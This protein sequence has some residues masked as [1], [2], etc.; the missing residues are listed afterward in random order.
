MFKIIFLNFFL[1]VTA[2]NFNLT[3]AS[4]QTA[5]KDVVYSMKKFLAA[6]NALDFEKASAYLSENYKQ[7][8]MNEYGEDFVSW[9][10]KSEM[11]YLGSNLKNIKVLNPAKIRI[12]SITAVEDCGVISECLE[13]YYWEQVQGVWKI[14]DIKLKW[15]KSWDYPYSNCPYKK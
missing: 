10:S 3:F 13:T 1:F 2:A 9:A 15:L 8:F 6:R 11:C 14:T 5:V 12:N 7:N 4:E